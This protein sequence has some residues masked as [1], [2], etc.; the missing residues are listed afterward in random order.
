M[1]YIIFISI[2]YNNNILIYEVSFYNHE[3]SIE[4]EELKFFYTRKIYLLWYYYTSIIIV[5]KIKKPTF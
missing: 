1:L 4:T 3:D 2:L 5:Q